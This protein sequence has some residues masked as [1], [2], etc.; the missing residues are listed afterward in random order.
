MMPF[1]GHGLR[2]NRLRVLALRNTVCERLARRSY[3]G[4]LLTGGHDGA[5]LPQATSL[6]GDC[7]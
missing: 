4:P 1:R 5:S 7:R 3:D 6:I 2:P